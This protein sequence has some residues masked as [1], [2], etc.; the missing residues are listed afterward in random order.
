LVKRALKTIDGLIYKNLA[1]VL[2]IKK[3]YNPRKIPDCIR[4]EDSVTLY[5]GK[6]G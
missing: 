1:N 3:N 5:G 4:S 2:E 6:Q